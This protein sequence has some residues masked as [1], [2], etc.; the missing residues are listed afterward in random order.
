M[1]L[2]TEVEEANEMKTVM[3]VPTE[4]TSEGELWWNNNWIDLRGSWNDMCD[5]S[6]NSSEVHNERD[7]CTQNEI[8]IGK[9][10]WQIKWN[11][12]WEYQ[13]EQNMKWS[14]WNKQ[15]LKNQN[16]CLKVASEI[17]ICNWN[18]I[19]NATKSNLQCK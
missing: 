8:C 18:D 4:W 9:Q 12:C 5:G 16:P 6:S 13:L 10:E 11:L 3:E 7:L 19:N 15:Q 1:E 2:A 17:E 14:L